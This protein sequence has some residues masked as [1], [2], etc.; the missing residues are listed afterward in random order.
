R[1]IQQKRALGR[2]HYFFESQIEKGIC[3]PKFNYESAM[4][5]GVMRPHQSVVPFSA[6]TQHSHSCADSHL[7][8]FAE[9]FVVSFCALC[10]TPPFKL[11]RLF[12]FIRP[13]RASTPV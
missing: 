2:V 8:L 3:S 6:E 10:L 1:T 7:D 9:A 4:I 5:V 12:T 13:P 11:A